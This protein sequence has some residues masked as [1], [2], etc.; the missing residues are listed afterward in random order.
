MLRAHQAPFTNTGSAATC[1][2]VVVHTPHRVLRPGH[3]ATRT[4]SHRTFMLLIL[5]LANSTSPVNPFLH[6][7]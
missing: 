3:N 5:S 4:L 7:C 6:S 1:K 2:Q